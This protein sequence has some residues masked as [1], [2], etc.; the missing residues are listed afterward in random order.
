M[1]GTTTLPDAVLMRLRTAGNLLSNC[2]YNLAQTKGERLSARH[3][4]SLDEC[5]KEW[6]ESREALAAAINASE[7]GQA[8]I[9]AQLVTYHR[10]LDGAFA[11]LITRDPKFF[12]TKSIWWPACVA[13]GALIRRLGGTL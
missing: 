4:Q 3:A 13:G 10:A 7:L 6:D 1:T 9:L 5:R 12:P 11:M 8:E 2:A